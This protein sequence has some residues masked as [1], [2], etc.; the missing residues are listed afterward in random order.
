LADDDL[1][2]VFEQVLADGPAVDGG[3]VQAAEVYELVPGVLAADDAVAAR[4]QRVGNADAVRRLAPDG[5]L[6]VAQ[7]EG[8]VLQR[9]R[10]D[11]ESRIRPFQLFPLCPA[12]APC[13]AGACA[14]PRP[15]C[16]ATNN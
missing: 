12:R 14:P 9:P 3:A 1:V 2:A 6:L 15:F 16:R 11:G 10:D 13:R 7:P 4:E 5:H 8:R